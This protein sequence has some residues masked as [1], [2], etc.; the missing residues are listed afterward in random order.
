MLEWRVARGI[1]EGVVVRDGIHGAVNAR[2]NNIGPVDVSVLEVFCRH[3]L[4]KST[5]HTRLLALNFVSSGDIYQASYHS[6]F[7]QFNT[8]I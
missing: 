3:I 5:F 6:G 2:Y 7:P 8:L 4:Q 1:I